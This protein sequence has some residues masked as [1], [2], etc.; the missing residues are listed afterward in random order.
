MGPAAPMS[1][2]LPEPRG[3]EVPRGL[4]LHNLLCNWLRGLQ[5]PLIGYLILSK[6]HAP[7]TASA[8]RGSNWLL[9]WGR[10][11]DFHPGNWT[12]ARIG[13]VDHGSPRK[14][15]LRR[16]SAIGRT[17]RRALIG[18]GAPRGRGERLLKSGSQDCCALRA[19][20]RRLRRRWRWRGARRARD[21]GGAVKAGL[22][23]GV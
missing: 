18:A 9:R 21:S 5:A 12:S 22:E 11:L 10:G 14:D 1:D 3:A 8:T 19:R 17:S 15:W 6:V 16:T 23:R 7:L 4:R 13:H 2:P 20:E